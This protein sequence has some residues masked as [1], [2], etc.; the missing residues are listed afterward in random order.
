MVVAQSRARR[1]Q[2]DSKSGELAKGE[3]RKAREISLVCDPRPKY[4]FPL[5]THIG[6]SREEVD[7]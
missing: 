6:V 3:A 5:K 2:V 4:R 7:S 1:L